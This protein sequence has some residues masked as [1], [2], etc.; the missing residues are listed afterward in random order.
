LDRR[1]TAYHEAGHAVMCYLSGTR[2]LLGATVIPKD[3]DHGAVQF[4]EVP[5][6]VVKEIESLEPS[7]QSANWLEQEVLF[8]LS[9]MVAE[10]IE[11]GDYFKGGVQVDIDAATERAFL[12]CDGDSPEAISSFLDRKRGDAE[13]ILRRNWKAVRAVATALC[14]RGTVSASELT[15]IVKDSTEVTG[16]EGK[17]P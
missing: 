7:P 14:E 9:G 6:A 3:G 10:E 5:A 2:E 11:F 4:G 16:D 13:A 8:L 17:S 12:F 15:A 1:R